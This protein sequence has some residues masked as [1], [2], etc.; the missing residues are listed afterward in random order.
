MATYRGDTILL[1]WLKRVLRQQQR[2]LADL[3]GQKL[4]VKQRRSIARL[5]RE[6]RSLQMALWNRLAQQRRPHL[7][8]TAKQV[9]LMAEHWAH[10]AAELRISAPVAPP[11]NEETGFPAV[12]PPLSFS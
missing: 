6:L 9:D 1:R 7:L 5:V 2:L 12:E 11:P 10:V 3:Q 4:G 8:E